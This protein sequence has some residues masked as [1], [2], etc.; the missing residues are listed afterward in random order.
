MGTNN[1]IEEE[2]EAL[3]AIFDSDFKRLPPSWG[4]TKISINVSSIVVTIV[5]SAEYPSKATPFVSVDRDEAPEQEGR[6]RLAEK[7]LKSLRVLVRSQLEEWEVLPHR[8]VVCFS[9]LDRIK[10]FVEAHEKEHMSLFKAMEQREL[11]AEKR[12]GEAKVASVMAPEN[13][14]GDHESSLPRPKVH[15][16]PGRNFSTT[17]NSKPSPMMNSESNIGGG[18]DESRVSTT[19]TGAITRYKNEFE[20]LEL[21]GTGGYGSVYRVRNKLDAR[22][23]ACKKCRI[24]EGIFK[25][26]RREVTTI[27]RLLHTNI[28]RYYSAWLEEDEEDGGDSSESAGASGLGPSTSDT[29]DDGLFAQ[30]MGD[31]SSGFMFQRD[32]DDDDEDDDDDDDGDGDGDGDGEEDSPFGPLGSSSFTSN[33]G[34]GR[35]RRRTLFI[36]MEYC[37]GTL[38][39][40]IDKGGLKDASMEDI[41]SLF[42]QLVEALSFVHTKGVIHRDIKPLNVLLRDGDVRLGDFGLAVTGGGDVSKDRDAPA[43]PSSSSLPGE[44]K[45]RD[46]ESSLTAGIG[47]RLYCANEQLQTGGQQTRGRRASYGS[48]VDIFSAGIVLFEMVYRQPFATASERIHVIQALREKRVM[49]SEMLARDDVSPE[50]ATLILRM[51]SPDEMERPTAMELLESD[52]FPSP[53][54]LRQQGVANPGDMDLTKFYALAHESMRLKTI[55]RASRDKARGAYLSSNEAQHNLSEFLRNLFQLRGAVEVIPPVLTMESHRESYAADSTMLLNGSGH[56]VHLPKNLLE[57]WRFF[58]EESPSLVNVQHFQIGYVFLPQPRGSGS[59]PQHHFS[60]LYDVTAPMD[61][62]GLVDHDVLSAALEIA[63]ELGQAGGPNIVL[64]MTDWRLVKSL[65]D[66]LI[67]QEEV[68]LNALSLADRRHS[69]LRRLLGHAPESGD[70][71]DGE[72]ALVERAKSIISSCNT[73]PDLLVEAEAKFSS[74]LSQQPKRAATADEPPRREKEKAKKSSLSSTLG[75]IGVK[76]DRR[77]STRSGSLTDDSIVPPALKEIGEEE[78]LSTG[79]A[80]AA[81]QASVRKRFDV[82]LFHAQNAL[83]NLSGPL[84]D[85]NKVQVDVVLLLPGPAEEFRGQDGISF[86]VEAVDSTATHARARKTQRR[87]RFLLHGGHFERPPK[88][89]TQQEGIRSS[90]C[91]LVVHNAMASMLVNR[92]KFDFAQPGQT[93]PRN[94]PARQLF[95]SNIDVLVVLRSRGHNLQF[96]EGQTRVCSLLQALRGHG[97]RCS[98]NVNQL[99][100]GPLSLQQSMDRTQRESVLTPLELQQLRTLR[101]PLVVL[102]TQMDADTGSV[103]DLSRDKVTQSQSLPVGDLPEFLLSLFCDHQQEDSVLNR[104]VSSAS[105]FSLDTSATAYLVVSPGVFSSRDPRKEAY[106]RGKLIEEKVREYLSSLLGSTYNVVSI[107]QDEKDKDRALDRPDGEGGPFI[108]ASSAGVSDLQYFHSVILAKGSTN[109]DVSHF[110]EDARADRRHWLKPLLAFV[111]H[112]TKSVFLYSIGDDDCVILRELGEK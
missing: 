1:E 62:R 8:E 109:L 95:N 112:M 38:R 30:S 24:D 35:K 97:L 91:A 86:A 82:A 57:N 99:V 96:G 79:D 75:N 60:A 32:D 4:Q 111:R 69:L 64:S 85:A 106:R 40:L 74:L 66:A 83:N 56:I 7:D 29:G 93:R 110:S 107:A 59:H 46:E 94:F 10:E 87:P 41:L 77:R 44:G 98:F 15:I 65:L 55:P 42:R 37:D 2:L 19:G 101:I 25:K 61:C 108:F 11:D 67:L 81:L 105:T 51:T 63:Q 20:E 39:E 5:L 54:F 27:S 28:V 31:L 14:E 18:G 33:T 23:Y 71:S 36:L 88:A 89:Q 58:M 26:I 9:L 90:C 70:A 6:L 73:A 43:L 21:L 45:S 12:R 78:S 34:H 102:L 22:Y 47:T 3:E 53:F 50:L 72:T 92:S 80:R 100:S 48:A 76:R 13:F 84:R 17:L 52:V 16:P 49:P 68:E 103:L 104:E